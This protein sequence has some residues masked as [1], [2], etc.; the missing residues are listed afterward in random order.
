[1]TIY[2][3]AILNIETGEVTYTEFTPDE[4]EAHNQKQEQALAEHEAFIA[5]ELAKQ[6][7]KEA[8]LSK[9]A[10]LGLTPEEITAITGA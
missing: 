7:A 6:E 10:A 1:M 2:K 3:E 8:G 9:L 5:A 4:L